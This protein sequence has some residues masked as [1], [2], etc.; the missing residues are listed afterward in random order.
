MFDATFALRV[1]PA[2]IGINATSEVG[3]E[4]KKL[5]V[6]KSL[7]IT[8]K[9]VGKSEICERVVESIKAEGVEVD[10]WDGVK[11]EPSKDIVEEGVKD[12]RGYDA[13]VAL[14]GGSSID[15]AKL[16][17]LYTTHPADFYDYVPKPVGKGK[18]VTKP[19]KPLIAIPTTSGSGSETTCAAVVSLPDLELKVGILHEPM[20]PTLAII[21]PLNV[22]SAPPSV[23]AS[24]GMDA[25]MHAIEAY[26]TKPYEANPYKSIYS[27][28]NPMTDTFAEK[29]I[30]LI[31]K[32][33][34]RA[35]YNGYDVEARL[36]MAIAAYSAGIAFGNAGVHVPHAVAH[37]IGGRKKIP[38]G[39]CVS[40]AAPAVLEFVAPAVPEKVE[41]IAELLGDQTGKAA[42][43]LKRLMDDIGIPGLGDL[44]FTEQDVPEIVEKTMLLQRLLLL[45]PRNVTREDLEE[46]LRRSF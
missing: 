15:V 11:P 20:L 24:A 36:G 38:H 41:R 43:A 33:L 42:S 1:T 21:D 5:N 9:T 40:V 26:T 23:T 28:S 12:A 16:I 46:I 25:L 18:T 22:V 4:L 39:V 8:G 35:V 19:L 7:I 2:K 31:G 17:N 29:A 30:E 3:K 27:G 45:C 34:R 32:Y 14:G 6:K 10:V 37:A 13:F 44:G